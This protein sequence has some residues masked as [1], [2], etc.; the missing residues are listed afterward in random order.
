MQGVGVFRLYRKSLLA[1][2]LGVEMPT[3]AEMLKA[4]LIERGGRVRRRRAQG[5]SWSPWRLSCVRDGSSAHFNVT[6]GS[7]HN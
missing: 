7:T 5:L 3:G 1:A 4:G 6:C 2:N